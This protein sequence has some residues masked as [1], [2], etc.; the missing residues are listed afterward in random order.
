MRLSPN[1]NGGAPIKDHHALASVARMER[2]GR[3]EAPP[4]DKLRDTH[5]LLFMGR[6]MGFAKGST[7]AFTHK[8]R[9]LTDLAMSALP[10]DADIRAS[11]RPPCFVPRA[12]LSNC[13][14]R[15]LFD[16]FVGAQ[17]GRR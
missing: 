7:R 2:T 10:S 6:S 5:Q 15:G 4:D 8:S 14:K 16:H 3:R 13:N 9:T 17:Q 1:G 12:D 11:L